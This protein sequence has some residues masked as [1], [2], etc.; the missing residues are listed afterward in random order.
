MKKIIIYIFILF[1]VGCSNNDKELIKNKIEVYE[2]VY[3]SDLV[4]FE[5]LNDE[6][7]DTTNVGKK[8]IIIKYLKDNKMHTIEKE[9]EIVDT[10]LPYAGCANY[11]NYEIGTSFNIDEVVFC[12]DNYTVKPKC[13]IV[14]NYDLTKE[15][16]YELK[17]KAVDESGNEYIKDFNLNVY[18]KMPD[19][20]SQKIIPFDE[21]VDKTPEN[22]SIMIDVSKWQKDI[23]W[24][25]VKE[26]GINYVMLR[27][28]TQVDVN[29]GSVMDSYFE[30][31]IKEA[32]DNGIKVGV[33]Y[34]SYATNVSEAR[35]Q[36][37]WVVENLKNYDIDLPVAFDWETWKLFNVLNINIHELNEIANT[38]LSIIEENGYRGI[39]YGSKNYMINVWDRKYPTWLAHYTEETDYPYEYIMWQF[40]SSGNI[41]GING[42][43]D[44]NFCYNCN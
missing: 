21:I 13:G 23:D 28:G 29:E 1:L 3:L 2:D 5:I 8:N 38:F 22:A 15:G 30:K 10:T 16:K 6:K 24:K 43:V 35:E 42:N 36:A 14:G 19:S 27:L 20:V 18:E 9:I 39:N 32:H 37:N 41:P 7:I 33:Y 40:T 44:V 12:G 31:N 17:Y 34:F 11:Y 25:V 4:D 26:S